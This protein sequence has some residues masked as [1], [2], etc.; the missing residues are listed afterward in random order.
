MNDEDKR[1]WAIEQA[2]KLHGPNSI[3]TEKVIAEAEKILAW[4][5]PKPQ[6]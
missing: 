1:R 5:A 3:V 2:I 4:V 6:K